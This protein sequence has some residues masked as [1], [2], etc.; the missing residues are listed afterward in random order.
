MSQRLHEPTRATLPRASFFHRAALL[1]GPVAVALT[2]LALTPAWPGELEPTEVVDVRWALASAVL[3]TVATFGLLRPD[4]RW[5]RWLMVL[6][7][8]VAVTRFLVVPT[9][10]EDGTVA[11]VMSDLA[12]AF[13]FCVLL[14]WI[15]DSPLAH[16][17]RAWRARRRP[18][19]PS[20]ATPVEVSPDEALGLLQAALPDGFSAGLREGRACAWWADESS[21]RSVVVHTPGRGWV[22]TEVESGH[23]DVQRGEG[24]P[25]E[26]AVALRRALGVAVA[27][28][29]G[30]VAVDDRRTGTPLGGE[31]LVLA[32]DGWHVLHRPQQIW[33]ERI[34]RRAWD[35]V[36][37]R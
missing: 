4:P 24:G 17:F 19:A 37:R 34:T 18:E 3:V 32:E 6:G 8:L 35:A 5:A 12:A 11:G 26:L 29:S 7:I 20:V 14:P 21:G 28:R 1:V 30:G 33:A 31:L 13:G 22:S 23:A 16:R 9:T 10:E 36:R 15:Q 27:Y 25:A 2:L